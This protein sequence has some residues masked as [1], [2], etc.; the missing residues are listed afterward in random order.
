VL[1][2]STR[3]AAVNVWSNQY[4][5]VLPKTVCP[6]WESTELDAASCSSTRTCSARASTVMPRNIGMLIAPMSA[7][8]CAA[9][10]A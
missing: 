10:L 8:V 2:A 1:A 6:I 3:I 7:S 4:G 9:F 5:Q